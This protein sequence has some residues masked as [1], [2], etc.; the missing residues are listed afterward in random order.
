MTVINDATVTRE[1]A[2]NGD[3]TMVDAIL[4]FAERFAH[5]DPI[6]ATWRAATV[7]AGPAASDTARRSPRR[8]R[9]RLHATRSPGSPDDV[10][11]SFAIVVVA[12]DE[13][14]S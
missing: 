11:T 12:I 6:A 7:E 2:A 1:G 8:G 4:P 13:E 14:T 5:R 10:A 9:A 3:K